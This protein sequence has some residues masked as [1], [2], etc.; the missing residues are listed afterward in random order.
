MNNTFTSSSTLSVSIST[1]RTVKSCFSCSMSVHAGSGCWPVCIVI[2]F[3]APPNTGSPLITPT[4]GLSGD[5]TC[6]M[7]R[8]KSY[9]NWRSRFGARNG[10][11]TR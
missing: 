11:A 5:N 8:V 10:I 9:S 2:G 4:T 7:A 3:I 1:R 6:V